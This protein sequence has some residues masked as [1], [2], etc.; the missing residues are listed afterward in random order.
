MKNE[1]LRRP[2][3]RRVLGDESL[4]QNAS[5]KYEFGDKAGADDERDSNLA[6]VEMSNPNDTLKCKRH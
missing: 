5:F 1:S 3:I 6:L 2:G 4:M